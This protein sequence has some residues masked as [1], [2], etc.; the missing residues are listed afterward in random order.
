[1]MER[2][3]YIQRNG[4]R[5]YDSEG[6]LHEVTE[7][8]IQGSRYAIRVAS[9]AGAITG[10]VFVQVEELTHNWNYY[11][12]L[13]CGLAQ[14]S[15]SGKAL[16]I[17]LFNEGSFTVSLGALRSIMYGKEKFAFVMKIPD[18][19]V[20]VSKMKRLSHDQMQI[21]ATV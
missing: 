6:I 4:C 13:T 15:A 10:R 1:M 16:N 20:Q 18:Q 11:L 21:S 3:G 7:V 17:N 12:G 8:H 2:A 5:A 9:L 14:V 19:S